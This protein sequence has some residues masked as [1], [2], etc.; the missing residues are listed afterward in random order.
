MTGTDIDAHGKESF[1]RRKLPPCAWSP[2]RDRQLLELV[3]GERVVH[4]GC[5]DAPLTM[6]SLENGTLLHGKLMGVA[7][8]LLGVDID[9]HGLAVLE[10]RVG[11]RYLHADATDITA[12]L[13]AIG[14]RPTVILASDVIEHIPNID[15]FLRALAAFAARCEP[16]P[17]LVL[18]TPNGLS[19]RAPIVAAFGLE[20]MHPDHRVVFTPTTLSRSLD[21]AG[22]RA[23]SWHTYS[24]TF[25]DTWPRRVVDAGL[26]MLSRVRPPLADGMIVIAELVD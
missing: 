4:V 25:G 2:D 3:R 24:V 16:R 17:S 23:C 26:R 21:D 20:M 13:P 19:V 14:A 15:R 8:D 12:L 18:S 7:G 1:F 22:F 6:E 10:T 11:G 5:T 9:A